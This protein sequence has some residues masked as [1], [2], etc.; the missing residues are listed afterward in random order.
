[1]G[2][3]LVKLAFLAIFG[4]TAFHLQSTNAQE[5]AGVVTLPKYYHNGMVI[6]ADGKPKVWGFTDTPDCQ[7]EVN[8]ACTDQ[9]G[10]R[11]VI[12]AQSVISNQQADPNIW[13]VFG[14]I[15]TNWGGTRVEAWSS[16]DALEACAVPPHTDAENPQ[17]SNSNLWNAM[18]VPLLRQTVKG[19]V[20]YQGESNSGWNRDLYPCTFSGLISDWRQKFSTI[21]EFA[22]FGFVQLSTDIGSNGVE[23]RWHQTKDVGFVPN[24]EMPNVFMAVALDTYDEPSGIH[25]RYKQIVGERMSYAAANVVYGMS[26]FP[27]NGPWAMSVTLSGETVEIEFDQDFTYSSE[28]ISGFYTCCEPLVDCDAFTN[29]WVQVPAEAVTVV[30]GENK[31]LV[32]VTGGC[33]SALAYLW[34]DVPVLAYK[35]APIYANDAFRMPAAPWKM[36]LN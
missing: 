27:T 10:I 18:V 20:W 12:T 25:P 13:E 7:V 32:D 1:M 15:E 2:P 23:I 3:I 36:A 29:S 11:S 35:G 4:V 19:F 33:S 31:I 26:E 22:P 21:E 5:C 28:E 9:N 16:S 34:E 17:N 14:L 6:Q 30:S 8:A 24:S